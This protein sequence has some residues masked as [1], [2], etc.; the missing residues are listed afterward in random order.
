MARAQSPKST[1]SGYRVRSSLGCA[2]DPHQGRHPAARERGV[3][4]YARP[5]AT[6]GLSCR[7]RSLVVSAAL[8]PALAVPAVAAPM[9]DPIFALIEE[10]RQAID[11]RS[12]AYSQLDE[13]EAAIRKEGDPRPNGLI[14]WRHWMIGGSEIERV[15]DELLRNPAANPK[16]I[17]KEYER[18]R[19]RY[20]AQIEAEQQW[21]ER[22]GLTEL[23]AENER[24]SDREMDL[25]TQL[26]TT[27]P[28]TIGGAAALLTYVAQGMEEAGEHD[29][30][31]EALKNVTKALRQLGCSHDPRI[32]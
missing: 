20:Q 2:D 19:A 11:A 26:S 29:W 24:L 13:A 14:V 16:K 4:L 5:S 21:F 12:T 9:T 30:Q 3:S 7:E 10:H 17:M 25:L 28:T 27:P 23:R 8:L 15:R 22:N 32:S 18:A 1:L 31:I 6:R